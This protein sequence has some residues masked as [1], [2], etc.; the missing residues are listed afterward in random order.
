MEALMK[1]KKFLGRLATASLVLA[2]TAIAA[3]AFAQF[4]GVSGKVVDEK[5]NPVA[6]VEILISNPSNVGTTKLK[7]DA[8]GSYAALGLPPADYQIKATKGNLTGRVDRIRIASGGATTIPTITIK[9]GGAAAPAAAAM[10]P[11]E[12]E[13]ANKK[14]AEMLAKFKGAQAAAD[15]GNLDLALTDF[16]AVAAELPDCDLC[17]IQIADVQLKKKDEAAAETAYKKAI[18]INP[19]N[20]VPYA[21]LASLYNGQKKFDLANQMSAKATE[22]MSATGSSD[23]VAYVNQG[24][25]L[26]NQSKTAE[27]KAQ[28]EKAAQL[29]PKN[30]DAHYWLGM[31]LVNEGNMADA[32]KHMKE[33]LALAPTGQY[34]DTAKAILDSAK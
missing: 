27:A 7:T 25:I 10:S 9:A 33:Y 8:K 3:P 6:D 13:K 31:A 15:A 30:A 5:G 22:L 28:F 24:I 2:L 23:P 16:N 32:G 34:A 1:T 17:Y 4:G 26:W 18:E 12:A 19:G 11:E 20:S 21:A 14:K 29:D